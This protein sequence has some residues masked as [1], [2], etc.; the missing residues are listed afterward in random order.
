MYILMINITN[1]PCQCLQCI[2]TKVTF[3][4]LRAMLPPP[5]TLYDLLD[6]TSRH[7]NKIHYICHIVN[8][9][10]IVLF[11]DQCIVKYCANGGTCSLT[12]DIMSQCSC[13]GNWTG[14]NCDGK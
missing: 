3:C 4:L 7:Y 14:S 13:R 5:P 8:I 6:P 1:Q 9:Y 12:N 2:T 11:L 10:I